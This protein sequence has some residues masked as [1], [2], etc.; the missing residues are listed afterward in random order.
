M[1][2]S[3][4]R[5]TLIGNVGKDPDVKQTRDGRRMANLTIATTEQWKD[6]SGER[7]ERTEWHRVVVYNDGIAGVISSYVGKGSR[8]Y[9][10]GQLQTRKWQDKDGQDRFT[11]EVVIQGFGGQFMMLDKPGQGSDGGRDEYSSPKFNRSSA[12]SGGGLGSEP[13]LGCDLDEEIPF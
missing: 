7:Q 12:G 10:E 6:K 1:S 13:D 5:V 11:T 3:L 2:R 4:N 9:V 8:V